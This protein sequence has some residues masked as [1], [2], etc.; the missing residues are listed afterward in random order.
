MTQWIAGASILWRFYIGILFLESHVLGGLHCT[1]RNKSWIMHLHAS[2][3]HHFPGGR[4]PLWMACWKN[5]TKHT[6]KERPKVGSRHFTGVSYTSCAC[7]S[8]GKEV[9]KKHPQ[10]NVTQFLDSSDF[11]A[12]STPRTFFRKNRTKVNV[13]WSNRRGRYIYIYICLMTSKHGWIPR[14]FFFNGPAHC[15]RVQV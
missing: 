4:F 1:N 8:L 2:C 13:F 10:L 12:T 9:E 11:S 7:F 6:F 14:A 5:W 15:V 3:S